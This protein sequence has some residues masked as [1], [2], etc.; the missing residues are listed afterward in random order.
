MGVAQRTAVARHESGHRHTTS[1]TPRLV[2]LGKTS[3]GDT[4]MGTANDNDRHVV[5]QDNGWAVVKEDHARASAVT[6]TQK[7]AIDRAREIVRN[8]GG[9]EVVIHGEDGK[10][11]AKD[12][13]APGN[14]PR[15][16]KG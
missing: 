10:I 1:A 11:R 9:G 5:K 15:S 12:T 8:S 13:V 2:E 6:D 3:E 14:D 4:T 16:S 7:E